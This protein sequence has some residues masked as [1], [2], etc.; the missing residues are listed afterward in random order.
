MKRKIKFVKM[1]GLGN[2]FVIIDRISQPFTISTELMARIGHRTLG[3]GCDQILIVDPPSQPEYDFN[4]RIFNANGEEVEQCGNGA[5]CFGRYVFEKGL[6]EKSEI[7]VGCLANPISI[8]LADPNHIEAFLG[9]PKFAPNSK[10]F[11]VKHLKKLSTGRYKLT[12]D[13]Q[14]KEATLLSIG[15]PHCVLSV[16]SVKD[17]KTEYIGKLLQQDICFPN[18]VNVSFVEVLARNH[19]KL[20]VYERGV[21]ETQACGTAACASVIAGVLQNELNQ[22]VQVDMPGGSLEVSWD[23]QKGVSIC[24]STNIVFEGRFVINQTEDVAFAS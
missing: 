15:N 5:R 18:G 23:K 8:N 3:V 2:D 19:I 21:G 7:T 14:I 10:H 24:G 22:T 1:H 20:R 9:T 12:I 16:P 17:A 4:Y 11:N 6:T 13:H